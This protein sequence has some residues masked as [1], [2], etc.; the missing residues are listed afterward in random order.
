M[1][2]RIQSTLKTADEDIV[3]YKVLQKNMRSYHYSDFIW[4]IGKI[5]NTKM[6]TINISGVV[7]EGFHSYSSLD[8]AKREYFVDISPC[9]IVECRIPKDANYYIGT[10]PLQCLGYVSNQLMVKRVISKEELFPDFN[11]ET[12]PYKEG[13]Q[14]LITKKGFKPFKATIETIQPYKILNMVFVLT[15]AFLCR[16]FNTLWD[17]S[18]RNT[19]SHIEKAEIIKESIE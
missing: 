6:G 10:Q 19:I 9:I 12:F 14:V 7:E 18:I 17:G 3:C 15:D 5:Y 1:C 13:Q 4:E 8:D 16:G 2:L 11:F